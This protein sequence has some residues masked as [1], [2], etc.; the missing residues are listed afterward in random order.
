M[1]ANPRAP[2]QVTTTKA[3]RDRVLDHMRLCQNEM[4]N[5]V[6]VGIRNNPSNNGASAPDVFRTM[7]TEDNR[8]ILHHAAR[9]GHLETI[10]RII[11][12]L[13]VEG[14]IQGS[15][16]FNSWIQQKDVHGNTAL[17]MAV[18]A[19][20]MSIARYLI[21]CDSS[22]SVGDPLCVTVEKIVNFLSLLQIR[23]CCDRKTSR[24]MVVITKELNDR[25]VTGRWPRHDRVEH[26]RRVARRV[27]AGQ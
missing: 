8:T 26:E 20:N 19:G 13:H 1:S 9:E 25:A 5:Q 18:Q 17:M 23:R 11:F 12:K 22:Q 10:K 2:F 4:F 3:E 24:T 16:E 7:V 15:Y 27:L 6:I 21:E 14:I